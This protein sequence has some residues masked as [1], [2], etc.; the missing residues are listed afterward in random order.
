MIDS[1]YLTLAAFHW[2]RANECGPM[3]RVFHVVRRDSAWMTGLPKVIHI[4]A[5][6]HSG[7]GCERVAGNGLRSGPLL[8]ERCL[9]CLKA[10]R[11]SSCFFVPLLL[12]TAIADTLQ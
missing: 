1:L 5:R 8:A 6:R 12:H 10:R 7:E 4:L 11:K 2:P 9:T 3:K